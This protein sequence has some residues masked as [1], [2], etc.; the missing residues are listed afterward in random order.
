MSPSA[1]RLAVGLLGQAQ[2]GPLAGD[3]A[4]EVA[5]LVVDRAGD[6][7]V[8]RV[9][10]AGRDEG[11]AGH[12]EL[13]ADDGL[14]P[15]GRQVD[16]VRAH[17]HRN[18]LEREERAEG[19]AD[20]ALAQRLRALGL[21]RGLAVVG[22]E[23]AASRPDAQARPA[24]EPDLD[25]PELPVAGG[26]R[27]LVGE[28]VVDLVVAQDPAEALGEVVGVADEEPAGVLGQ[29]VQG[30]ALRLVAA[31]LQ[32]LPRS[33]R[34]EDARALEGRAAARDVRG[35]PP[36][37]E[38][39]EDDARAGRRVRDAAHVVG[40]VLGGAEADQEAVGD[41]HHHLASREGSEALHQALDHRER[42]P[43]PRHDL[44]D[45][46]AGL[47]VGLLARA[48]LAE[49]VLGLQDLLD[50]EA[51]RL[52]VRAVDELGLV[53]AEVG[54]AAG[55]HRLVAALDAPDGLAEGGLVP[56][57]VLEDPGRPARRGEG[58]EVVVRHLLVH[59]ARHR[60]AGLGHVARRGVQV[61]DGQD[62]E[63][64]ARGRGRRGRCRGRRG[65]G[66]GRGARLRPQARPGLH[67]EVRERL[68]LAVL[69][70]LELALGDPV[71]APAVLAGHHHVD[72]DELGADGG[73]GGGR[74]RALPRA[75]LGL[76][77]GRR[78]GGDEEERERGHLAFVACAIAFSA[79]GAMTA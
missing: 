14:G 24:P 1:R 15:R 78:G 57:E 3:L 66:R 72:L 4:D 11:H 9:A 60:P 35:Q 69:E 46:P 73:Q 62:E 61:V 30:L 74:V 17:P 58:D 45:H 49:V 56:G 63:A 2:L 33:R 7:E 40:A 27:R 39:V 26:V 5:G 68:R 34:G 13:G 54:R 41:E 77:R 53:L 19:L 48:H 16:E 42:P 55:L 20:L 29:R 79:S 64:S 75:R 47:G 65:G 22:S 21:R 59:E 43:R 6:L 23:V 37:V 25:L 12:V 18:A 28:Q 50:G 51:Q 76:G 10:V 38:G 32:A 8:R 44:E 52:D 70:D 71:D 31:R 36:R 67:G